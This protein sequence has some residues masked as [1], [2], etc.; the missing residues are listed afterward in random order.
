VTATWAA[1]SLSILAQQIP[2]PGVDPFKI[3]QVHA[4][5]EVD[6]RDIREVDFANRV[7]ALRES[8]SGAVELRD[9]KHSLETTGYSE[10]IWL[11]SVQYCD[12]VAVVCLGQVYVGGSSSSFAQTTIFWLNED[13]GFL[14]KRAEIDYAAG[15][16]E[17]QVEVDCERRLITMYS[18]SREQRWANRMSVGRINFE[19]LEVKSVQEVPIDPEDAPK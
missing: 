7:C 12:D 15:P 17:I 10:H 13:R 18:A 5:V 8:P 4:P 1:I 2:V 16:A 19:T 3:T 14:V 6:V 11:E 9:G